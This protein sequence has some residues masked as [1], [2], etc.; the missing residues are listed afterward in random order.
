MTNDNHNSV[1]I[2]FWIS[3]HRK[4]SARSHISSVMEAAV[5]P[6]G[7]Q[8]LVGSSA[9]DKMESPHSL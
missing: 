2:T 4:V 1:N 7:R 8:E 3:I 5:G 6:A 9:L